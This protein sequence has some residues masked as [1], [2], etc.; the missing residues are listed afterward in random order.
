MP[1]SIL[2][3]HEQQGN[4]HRIGGACPADQGLGPDF[5]WGQMP[6]RLPASYARTELPGPGLGHPTDVVIYSDPQR[7]MTGPRQTGRRRRGAMLCGAY[8]FWS[9]PGAGLVVVSALK[10][11]QVAAG[12]R[13]PRQQER[14]G[15]LPFGVWAILPL[16]NHS[17]PAGNGPSLTFLLGTDQGRCRNCVTSPILSRTGG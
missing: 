11:V 7:P 17:C 12:P 2:R 6:S 13:L 1:T 4:V 9:G 5:F 3:C 8:V 16:A 10:E 15:H 14:R